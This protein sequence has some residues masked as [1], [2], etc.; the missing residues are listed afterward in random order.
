MSTIDRVPCR[1]RTML[2]DHRKFAV[3]PARGRSADRE[4]NESGPARVVNPRRAVSGRAPKRTAVHQSPEGDRADYATNLRF[5]LIPRPPALGRILSR[6]DPEP[7]GG[8]DDD[9]VSGGMELVLVA[10]HF[11]RVPAHD[12]EAVVVAAGIRQR[13]CELANG[14]CCSGSASEPHHQ[15]SAASVVPLKNRTTPART[16]RMKR[17]SSLVCGI[18][19]FRFWLI[20]RPR[21]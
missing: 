3:R 5:W 18:N 16:S 17:L 13:P 2:V 7:A 10:L 4:R 21:A 9:D 15:P 19:H 8:V 12:L 6:P 11:R 1:R 20:P 14:P